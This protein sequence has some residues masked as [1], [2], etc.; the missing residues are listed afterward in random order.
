MLKPISLCNLCRLQEVDYCEHEY[1]EDQAVIG[2]E[3]KW[4]R[5]V[6]VDMELIIACWTGEV[7]VFTRISNKKYQH[8]VKVDFKVKGNGY[9]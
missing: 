3:Y 9:M 5:E 1:Q 4:Q 6:K 7:V 8:E 2:P